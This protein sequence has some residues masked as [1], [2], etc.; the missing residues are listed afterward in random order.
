MAAECV[1]EGGTGTVLKRRGILAAA[2]AAVAGIVARQAARPVTANGGMRTMPY[3]S[4]TQTG[5]A[6][7]A[8]AAGIAN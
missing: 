5:I 2:G 1:H 3:N 8:D 6:P 7:G 4:G